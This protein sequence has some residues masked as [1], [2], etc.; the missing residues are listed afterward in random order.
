GG[1]DAAAVLAAAREA[2]V[3]HGVEPEYLALVDADS[4]APLDVVRDGALVAV[5][6][7]VGDVR[8]IDNHPLAPNRSP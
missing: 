8:L 6:A 7:R 5:A 1:R 4:F 2:I 3:R